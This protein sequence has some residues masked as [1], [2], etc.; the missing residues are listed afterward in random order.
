MNELVLNMSRS[1]IRTLFQM[2]PQPLTMKTSC[3]NQFWSKSQFQSVLFS[4]FF[5]FCSWIFR[6]FKRRRHFAQTDPLTLWVRGSDQLFLLETSSFLPSATWS[7]HRRPPWSHRVRKCVFPRQ[8]T[9]LYFYRR[10]L[11]ICV[12]LWWRRCCRRRL[13]VIR[14]KKRWHGDVNLRNIQCF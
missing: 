2:E 10:L 13:Q 14:R 6:A 3:L 4:R 5:W 8:P 7:I 12:W 11:Y 1:H 9:L